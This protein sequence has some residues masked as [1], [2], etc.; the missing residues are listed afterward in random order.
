MNA[1]WRAL[2]LTIFTAGPRSV[3]THSARNPNIFASRSGRNCYTSCMV[4]STFGA[5]YAFGHPFVFLAYTSAKWRRHILVTLCA[6]FPYR[7]Q[8]W[9][10][11]KGG[12]VWQWGSGKFRNDFRQC[13]ASGLV[14]LSVRSCQF[15]LLCMLSGGHVYLVN[16]FATRTLRYLHALMAARRV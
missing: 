5:G 10:S 14:L 11:A 9:P 13:A 4:D 6:V 1:R 16:G 2:V 15:A 8:F 7:W 12:H 3:I